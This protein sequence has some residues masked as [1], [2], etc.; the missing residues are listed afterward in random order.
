MPIKMTDGNEPPVILLEGQV[1]IEETDQLF[2]L[3][4]QDPRPTIDLSACE[5]LHTAALQIL[6]MLKPEI[7][8]PAPSV[9]WNRCL[10]IC[11]ENNN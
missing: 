5:H 1:S 7:A 3:L 10:G 9:F 2:E 4:R 11:T 6:L 8:A